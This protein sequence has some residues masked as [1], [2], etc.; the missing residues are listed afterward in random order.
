MRQIAVE[1]DIGG[2]LQPALDQV[3]QQESEI[4]QHVASG[5]PGIELDGVE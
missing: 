4:V 2:R 1:H 5:D 3:H